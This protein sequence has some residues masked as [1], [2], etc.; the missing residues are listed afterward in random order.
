MNT[1]IMKFGRALLGLALVAVSLVV[2]P[3][4]RASSSDEL[5]DA[6][7][8]KIRTAAR[9]E[10]N[11]SECA[12]FKYV[13]SS[14]EA[15]VTITNSV[16]TAYAPFNVPDSS[17]FGTASSSYTFSTAYDTMGELCDAVDALA[18]YQCFL[19]GCRRDDP[20][21]RMRN[22][23]QVSGT[24]DLKGVGGFTV[25]LD[26]GSF[27]AGEEISTVYDIRVGIVPNSGR[28]VVL[29][30]CTGNHNVAGSIKVYGKLRKFEGAIDGITRSD[31]TVVWSAAT[32]DDTDLQ[33]PADLLSDSGWIEFA[34]DAHVVISA[35]NGTGVQAAANFL[36]CQWDEKE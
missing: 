28:R 19:V 10:N 1:K 4:A 22:Q 6:D 26:T 27:L 24:N 33:I 14:T 13:G 32:A 23:T 3:A 36:E 34:R 17:N 2:V 9:F 15:L 16:I 11:A 20:T 30:T 12:N 7:L 35:G 25:K 8:N 5:N 21:T 29:K 18:N 31:T